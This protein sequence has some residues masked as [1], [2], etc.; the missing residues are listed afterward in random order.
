MT[1]HF[2]LT[3]PTIRTLLTSIQSKTLGHPLNESQQEVY[4]RYDGDT[5][6]LNSLALDLDMSEA[7]VEDSIYLL[8]ELAWQTGLL[9]GPGHPY[10]HV[11]DDGNDAHYALNIEM[12]SPSGKILRLT[13]EWMPWKHLA[14]H[15]QSDAVATLMGV[16]DELVTDLNFTLRAHD[17]FAQAQ[18]AAQP[19]TVALTEL[20]EQMLSG[21]YGFANSMTCTEVD[22]LARVL[23]ISGHRDAAAFILT[24]HVEADDEG[25]PHAAVLPR[26]EDDSDDQQARALLYVTALASS[27]ANSGKP[28]E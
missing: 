6:P 1:A 24:A 14:K 25:D 13:T 23:A 12:S 9:T 3:I 19:L 8:L 7:G 5:L 15:E 27:S 10:F 2:A 18:I 16:L 20:A 21:A 11:E 28:T 22:S 26:Q 4:A 17:D